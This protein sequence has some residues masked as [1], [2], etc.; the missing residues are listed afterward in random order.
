MEINASAGWKAVGRAE[1]MVREIDLAATGVPKEGAS[2]P[3][4][5]KDVCGPTDLRVVRSDHLHSSS[6]RERCLINS[7]RI[8][9]T[10]S[11]EKNS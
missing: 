2:S 11:V 9:M 4:H 1:M 3:D 6:I 5:P 8:T 7:M 10:N